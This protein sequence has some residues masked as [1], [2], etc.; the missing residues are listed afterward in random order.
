MSLL[1]RTLQCL[2]LG[3]AI[4]GCVGSKGPDVARRDQPNDRGPTGERW[5]EFVSEDPAFTI[6]Y[7]DG[8]KAWQEDRM[9]SIEPPQGDAAI[10]VN[11]PTTNMSLDEAADSAIQ[12]VFSEAIPIT[13]REHIV[14]DGIHGVTQEIE[15]KDDD[16]PRRWLTLFLLHEGRFAAIT[17]NG[18]PDVIARDRSLYEKIMRTFRFVERR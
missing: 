14:I 11:V 7:P 5:Q 4:S 12:A 13:P 17:T 10:T 15:R 6:R 8:W 2:L 16:G 1:M 3:F 9:L 18:T